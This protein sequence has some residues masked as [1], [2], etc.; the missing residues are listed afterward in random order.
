MLG[1]NQKLEIRTNT[2]SLFN[3]KIQLQLFKQHD[4]IKPFQFWTINVLQSKLETTKSNLK[5]RHNY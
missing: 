1:V 5:E 2:P 4:V 3:F